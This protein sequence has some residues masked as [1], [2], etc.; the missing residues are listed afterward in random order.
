MA[1]QTKKP[2]M[3]LGIILLTICC[4]KYFNVTNYLTLGYLH[5]NMHVLQE[6][7]A[8]HYLFSVS[9]YLLSFIGA[10]AFSIPGSSI[11]TI[12]AG[13]LFG[14]AGLLYALFGATVGSALLFLAVRYFIGSWVQ[15]RYQQKLAGF[16][17][18][19]D[20][21]GRYYLLIVRLIAV[22]PFCLV[23]MLSGLTK[24]SLPSFLGVTLIGLIPV[25]ALYIF[26]G[27][28]VAHVATPDDFFSPSVMLAFSIFVLF[29]VAMMPAV[30]NM[31]KRFVSLIRNK[32]RQHFGTSKKIEGPFEKPFI[33]PGNEKQY[34]KSV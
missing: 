30:F 2:F 16:N 5:T 4:C 19:I 17:Q 32:K 8:H 14:W 24:L 7:C 21:H 34:R 33:A 25:S 31:A 13:L 28:Q 1:Y 27:I 11:F 29:K 3:A 9:V 22:L 12:A 26:A 18:E 10:T 15:Q 20:T 6:Y 23:N